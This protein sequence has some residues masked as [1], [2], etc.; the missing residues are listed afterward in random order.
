MG[1]PLTQHN[2]HTQKIYSQRFTY[3]KA[4]GIG[5]PHLLAHSLSGHNGSR[6]QGTGLGAEHLGLEAVPMRDAM[7]KPFYLFIYLFWGE[8]RNR[9]GRAHIHQATASEPTTAGAAEAGS[10]E[11][12]SGLPHNWARV[13]ISR[14]ME[15]G[16]KP[17]NRTQVLR[18]G[19]GVSLCS[20]KSPF[21]PRGFR[22][23]ILCFPLLRPFPN[24]VC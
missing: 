9:E 23:E 4:R 11:L 1:Q 19:T 7:P 22:E 20:I 8:N 3:S 24:H 16:T 6:S 12:C 2:T 13:C 5:I 17:R 10:W 14:K 18:C 15:S 21:P